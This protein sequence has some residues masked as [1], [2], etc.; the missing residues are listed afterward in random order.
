[1]PT[2]TAKYDYYT[3]LPRS[4]LRWLRDLSDLFLG[5]LLRGLRDLLASGHER[6]DRVACAL[7]RA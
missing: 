1:M 3:S 4:Y 5:R 7:V 6:T 2:A